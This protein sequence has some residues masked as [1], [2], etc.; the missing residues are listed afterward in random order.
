MTRKRSIVRPI[1]PIEERIS[2]ICS[3]TVSVCGT[4][5]FFLLSRAK[6]RKED[7][8]EAFTAGALVIT[9]RNIQARQTTNLRLFLLLVSANEPVLGVLALRIFKSCV[10]YFYLSCIYIYVHKSFSKLVTITWP[11]GLLKFYKGNQI[12]QNCYRNHHSTFPDL[13]H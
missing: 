6:R 13:C 12:L 9:V 1:W 5:R 11:S 7:W 8:R 4:Q 10:N 2:V 3:T